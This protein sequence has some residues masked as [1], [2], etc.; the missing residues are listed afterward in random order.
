MQVIILMEELNRL[1]LLYNKFREL[2][3]NAENNIRKAQAYIS[4]LEMKV[5]TETFKAT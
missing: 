3:A 4:E 2:L 1:N 5:K